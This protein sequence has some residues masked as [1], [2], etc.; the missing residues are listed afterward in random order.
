VPMCREGDAW[1]NSGDYTAGKPTR[2]TGQALHRHG[3]QP[4]NRAENQEK[5]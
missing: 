1:Q 2:V 4:Y 5:T 3:A